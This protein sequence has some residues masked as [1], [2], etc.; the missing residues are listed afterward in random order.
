[1]KTFKIIT[2]YQENYGAMEG[3]DQGRWKNK[4]G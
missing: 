3:N 2:Q 1:M 4:G